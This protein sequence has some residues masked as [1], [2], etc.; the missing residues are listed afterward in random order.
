MIHVGAPLFLDACP[1]RVASAGTTKRTK[2][3]KV[4]TVTE[5]SEKRKGEWL[6]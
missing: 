4:Y 5:V 3:M 2:G 6:L 1:I